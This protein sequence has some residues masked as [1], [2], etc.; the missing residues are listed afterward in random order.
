M[1]PGLVRGLLAAFVA[2]L[3]L[4][5]VRRDRHRIDAGEPT[6]EVDVAA[7]PRAERANNSS[8]GLP[9]IGHWLVGSIGHK[10]NMGSA[11]GAPASNSRVEPAEMNRIPLAGEQRHRLVQ[12]QADDVGIGTDDL[13]QKRPGDALR[14]IA[15]GLAAPFAGG[16]IGLES[17]SD[18]R[19]KRTRVST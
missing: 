4:F 5:L 7:A 15:A 11:A 9:Q 14:R 16:Q 18:S 1:G 8:A 12:R 13:D 6:V 2:P 17:W 19:L 10:Q 3:V